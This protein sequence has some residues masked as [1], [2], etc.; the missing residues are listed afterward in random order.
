MVFQAAS[1]L[2]TILEYKRNHNSHAKII[3]SCFVDGI[4]PPREELLQLVA[5]MQ[6][7]GADIIKLVTHAAD[8]T[9]I[10]RIFSLLPYCQA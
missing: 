3:V 7:T 4:T 2:T 9:E 1:H 6:A 8:I 10:S 5:L